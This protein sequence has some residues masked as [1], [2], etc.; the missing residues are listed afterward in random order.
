MRKLEAVVGSDQHACNTDTIRLLLVFT[1][2]GKGCT[3][4]RSWNKMRSKTSSPACPPAGAWPCATAPWC[5]SIPTPEPAS[6]KP[7]TCGRDLDLDEHPVVGLHGKGDKWQTCRHG[8]RP[9]AC[10]A[11]CCSPVASQP[12]P[13][14]R[15]GVDLACF[16]RMCVRFWLHGS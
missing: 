9:P 4:T 16:Y 2:V 8:T 7:P 13:T 3:I 11:C 6:K 15:C 5:C 10:S 14:R 1:A 12:R